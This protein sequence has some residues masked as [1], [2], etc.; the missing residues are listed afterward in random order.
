MG[1]E[2]VWGSGYLFTKGI[3]VGLAWPCLILFA[4]ALHYL[5][6]HLVIAQNYSQLGENPT[7][8][9]TKAFQLVIITARKTVLPTVLLS[10]YK[11]TNYKTRPFGQ[12]REV[13]LEISLFDIFLSFCFSTSC[14]R[15][16]L[17]NN[18]PSVIEEVGKGLMDLKVSCIF[19]KFLF[20]LEIA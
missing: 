13:K 5:Q 10:V 16:I 9:F 17:A 8:I 7:N 2:G 3:K 1:E 20:Y 11:F 14:W 6:L 19:C 12:I 15:F 18:Q 4:P